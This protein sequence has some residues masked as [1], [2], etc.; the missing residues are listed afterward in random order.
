MPFLFGINPAI[1]LFMNGIGTLLFIL[2]TKGKAPAYLGSSFAFIAPANIVIAKFGYPYA[3]GGFVVVGFCGCV[4]AFIIKKCGTKWIDIVLPPAAMGPVVALIGL[5]LSATAASNAGLLGDSIQAANVWVF[6]ITL[7]VA[8]LGNICFR[9]FLSVIPI[10]IDIICGYI[11]AICFG[12]VDFS[13]VTSAKL[14]ALPNFTT[15]KFDINAILMILPVI[16]VITSEHIG[17]QVV[18]GKIV[19]R[20]LIKE[21][22]L[23]RS[24]LG[25]NFSTMISGLIGSVPTTTYGENIGVMAITGVYSVQ[26]IAGAAIISIIC[27]FVGPLSALIQTI[28]G[29]VIGGISFLLYGMIGTSGL[30]I[31]VDQHVDYSINKNLI[32]TSV[33][34]V[35]GLSS[36]TLNFGGIQLTGMVLACIVA[37]LLSLIFYIL[38]KFNL[39]ND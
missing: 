31:L 35:T 13:A 34:F 1:V 33:V 23:H 28:P 20:D 11:S 18:T 27:S 3:L 12:L 29:P 32:L 25:D 21:P 39:T 19:G 38:E 14:F 30:R 36:I 15:P 10:L 9:K 5:E 7:G 24:L 22:G 26:V 16:L 17:H 2:I 6:L 37:M 8:V 4:L